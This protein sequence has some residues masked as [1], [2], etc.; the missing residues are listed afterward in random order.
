MG[1]HSWLDCWLDK[2]PSQP[3]FSCLKASMVEWQ[4][5]GCIVG[6]HVLCWKGLFEWVLFWQGRVKGWMAEGL[7]VAWLIA[8]CPLDGT[9]RIP[10]LRILAPFRSCVGGEGDHFA[11]EQNI[12]IPACACVSPCQP[13]A[14]WSPRSLLGWN[15]REWRWKESAIWGL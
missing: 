1:I 7:G 10:F 6:W 12:H 4:L 15:P 2:C 13:E 9:G 5:C 3:F 14:Y 11:W 8:L